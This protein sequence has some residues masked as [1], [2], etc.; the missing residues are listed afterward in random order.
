MGYDVEVRGIESYPADLAEQLQ[1]DLKSEGVELQ[2]DPAFHPV[3]WKGG[4]LP[5][6][7]TAMPKEF[8]GL[9]LKPPAESYLELEL[10][11]NIAVFTV[12][13]SPSTTAFAL[14]CLG[15]ASMARTLRARYYDPQ[16]GQRAN[17]DKAMAL[18]VATNDRNLDRA[19]LS[20]LVQT[21]WEGRRALTKDEKARFKQAKL[22]VPRISPLVPAMKT[23]I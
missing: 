19:T 23:G 16:T 7:L 12:H 13:G 22:P 5:L 11:R 21:R 10:R 2:F 20:E 17:A 15:A 8:T 6:K 3:T 14:M 9:D 1:R 18:A 4:D